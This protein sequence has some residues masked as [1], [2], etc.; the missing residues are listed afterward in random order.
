VVISLL[1]ADTRPAIV[2]RGSPRPAGGELLYPF[3]NR[4]ATEEMFCKHMILRVYL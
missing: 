3:S 1:R 4:D 2:Q